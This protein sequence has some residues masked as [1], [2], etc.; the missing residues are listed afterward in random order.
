[1]RWIVGLAALLAISATA[2]PDR[3][4]AIVTTKERRAQYLAHARLWH[5]PGSL[6]AEDLAGEPAGAFP[7]SLEQASRANGITCTFEKPGHLIGGHSPK[8]LCRMEDHESLRLKYWDPKRRTGNREVF[9]MSA[10]TRLFRA[11][12]FESVP[13]LTLDVQCERCPENPM[14]GDGAPATRRYLAAMRQTPPKTL[15]VS[16]DDFDQGWAWRELDSAIGGLPTGSERQQQRTHFD[17]L[18]LLGVL[19]QHGDRK[20]QQQSLYCDS[21]VDT[22]LGK[23]TTGNGSSKTILVE[24]PAG[25]A[26]A[27]PVAAIIDNGATF[28]GAG[29]TS[30]PTT[31]KMNL[32]QWRTHRVFRDERADECRGNLTV[33]MAAGDMGEPNPLVSEDGRVFLLDR[34]H[35]L[36]PDHIRAIFTAARVDQLADHDSTQVDQW[37]TAFQDKV[38][39]IE[40]H[41]CRPLP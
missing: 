11:L 1:M 6:T 29:R 9:A 3:I 21:S 25:S 27:S 33:S 28:G 36:T 12:G 23:V 2:A 40:T 20:N 39:Q 19:I 5:D 32:D 30:N 10:A 37:V 4:S 17:A 13:V 7:D 34:L 35:R 24:G 38:R 14:T 16:S 15:I 8:F 22:A 31:A 18:T 41:H 26:C